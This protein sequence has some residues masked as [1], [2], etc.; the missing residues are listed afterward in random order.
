MRPPGP[1]FTSALYLGLRHESWTLPPWHQLTRGIPAALGEP[2]GAQEVAAKLAALQG[3]EGATLGPSTLH[4]FWDLFGVL[5]CKGVAIYVDEGAYSIM[6]WGAER[7]AASGV[8]VHTF[9]HHDVDGLRRLLHRD[10]FRRLR[11]VVAAD[12][13]CPQCGSPALIGEYLRAVR[14]FGGRLILDD[15]QALGILGRDPD[16]CAPYGRSGGGSLR[17]ANVG[18]ADVVLVSS[19]AKGFGVP[20]AVLSGSKVMVR[21]FESE[22]ETRVHCSPPSV[23]VIHAAKHALAVNE[24]YGDALRLRLAKRVIQFRNRLAEIGLAAPGG[25]FPV[26]TLAPIRGLDAAA[27]YC[28]LLRLGVRTVLRRVRSR[29]DARIS[30]LITA[31]HSPEEID[32]A[33]DAL[34]AIVG[35]VKSPLA[36]A[37]RSSCGE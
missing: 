28:R 3:C 11:P 34:A 26:Q 25:S 31:N 17:H 6:R 22:S 15:T 27:L 12:G 9:R 33:A 14:A 32:C 10:A 19:L 30:F 4:L 13:F 8:P 16:G 23:A 36:S 18:G 29:A 21:R 24:N 7:A 1:D 35:R 37:N 2:P 5:T 20:L